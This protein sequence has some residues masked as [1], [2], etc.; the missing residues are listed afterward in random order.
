MLFLRE[1]FK[2]GFTV[3]PSLF[4]WLYV[5]Y[6]LVCVFPSRFRSAEGVVIRKSGIINI[7]GVI[8]V[9]LFNLCQLS[10][11]IES[12]ACCVGC[13]V[14]FAWIIS[15][16]HYKQL[17]VEEAGFIFK[18]TL[19]ERINNRD[20]A[21]VSLVFIIAWILSDF[22]FCDESIWWNRHSRM[23]NIIHRSII[24][25]NWIFGWVK[26]DLAHCHW[27]SFASVSESLEQ[28][29]TLL[30]QFSLYSLFRFLSQLVLFTYLVF[31]LQLRFLCV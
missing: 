4:N 28:V 8:F 6:L 1:L 16:S 19:I 5:F 13:I 29:L 26:Q 2:Y 30:S 31:Y 23:L 15:L 3:F 14:I 24:M 25:L 27:F 7:K 20:I 22:M 11:Y 9:I 18:E 12:I 17:I 21:P 10:W